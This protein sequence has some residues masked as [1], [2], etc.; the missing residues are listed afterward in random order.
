MQTE[1]APHGL[2]FHHFHGGEHQPD[3]HGSLSAESFEAILLDV[4]LDRILGPRQWLNA[5]RVGRL[6]DTDVCLTFDDALK[7]QLA[8]CL[9]VLEHYR[10]EA[11][12]FIYS[13]PFEGV[14]PPLEIFRRFRYQ[15]YPHIDDYYR[16]FWTS[17]GVDLGEVSADPE[18]QRFLAAYT[19][20]FPFY[21]VNDICYRFVRDR[22]LGPSRYEA[23]VYSLMQSRGVDVD[24]L[25][26]GLWLGDDHLRQLHHKGH[27]IG[28]HSYDHPTNLAALNAADQ[29]AQY[30]RNWEHISRVCEPPVSMSH[31]CNSYSEVTLVLLAELGITCGFRSNRVPPLNGRPNASPLEIGRVDA[32]LLRRTS[33][34][35]RSA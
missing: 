22:V 18:Y 9:P 34:S 21:S 29:R 10:L 28:L 35:L 2:M 14:R 7:S 25:S 30:V 23:V 31:P 27:V 33:E 19:T 17:A 32:S 26:A 13:A 11:F 20:Q 1:Q 6:R 5:L 3:G 4:G 8:I 15:C 24:S 16:A 12:W